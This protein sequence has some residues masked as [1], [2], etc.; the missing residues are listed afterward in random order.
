MHCI[1]KGKT[2]TAASS[3]E[4]PGAWQAGGVLGL[5]FRRNFGLQ[6]GGMWNEC[7][8]PEIRAHRATDWSVIQQKWGCWS[9]GWRLGADADGFRGGVWM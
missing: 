6:Q 5:I 8:K 1:G 2:L 3:R 4:E 9:V 7:Q